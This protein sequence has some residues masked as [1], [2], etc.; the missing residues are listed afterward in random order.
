MTFLYDIGK[1]LLDFDFERSLRRLLPEPTPRSM[2]GIEALLA[3]KDDFEGGAIALD[4]YLELALDRLGPGVTRED[5]IAAWRDIFTPN[6][7][8]WRVVE[9]LRAEGHRLILFSNT[10]PIH[11]PW[12][13]EAYDIFSHFDDAVISYEA[14]SVKPTEAIYRHAIERHQLDPART[15]YIDDLPAN[16]ATGRALGFVTH[17][18]DVAD[19]P[20]FESWLARHLPPDSPQHP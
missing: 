14:G 6:L 10:N 2:A 17:Q 16:V 19:H 3:V 20:A 15:L 9:R 8:M 11:W 7:P 12:V 4:D 13:A 5:F 18:Y 1:V